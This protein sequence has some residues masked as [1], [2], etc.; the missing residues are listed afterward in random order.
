[1]ALHHLGPTGNCLMEL[2]WLIFRQVQKKR[3]FS[4]K[5]T[6]AILAPLSEAC[7]VVGLSKHENVSHIPEPPKVSYGPLG[8]V[9]FFRVDL[10]A[11][12]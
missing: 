12:Q 10:L 5:W 1:M 4:I 7:G 6:D 9:S 8:L 11:K 2:T 3:F